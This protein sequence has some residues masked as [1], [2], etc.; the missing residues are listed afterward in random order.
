MK[1]FVL[2]LSLSITRGSTA[3]TGIEQ[4]GA[5]RVLVTGEF[6]QQN[7]YMIE[8]LLEVYHVSCY[9]KLRTPAELI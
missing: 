9:L 7:I 2:P 8:L 3:L 4:T 6:L 5:C 1:P